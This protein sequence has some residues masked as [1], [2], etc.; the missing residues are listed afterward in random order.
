MTFHLIAIH[1]YFLLKFKYFVTSD[2]RKGEY[3]QYKFKT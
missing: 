3:L 1:S 2:K